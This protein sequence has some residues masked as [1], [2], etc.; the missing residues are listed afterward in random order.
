MHNMPSRRGAQF[1]AKDFLM[2]DGR[3]ADHWLDGRQ[4]PEGIGRHGP[5]DGMN[6]LVIADTLQVHTRLDILG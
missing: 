1:H 4:H 2:K 5:A 6:V 3:A